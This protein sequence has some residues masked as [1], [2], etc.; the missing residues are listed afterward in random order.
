MHRI[1]GI[2]GV[3]LIFFSAP[4]YSHEADFQSKESFSFYEPNFSE[5]WI[6]DHHFV[7]NSDLV[8]FNLNEYLKTHAPHLLPYSEYISH[9]SGYYS[10]SPKVI[11][12]LIEMQSS[13]ISQPGTPGSMDN[14]LEQLAEETGFNEQIKDVLAHLYS[15]FYQYQTNNQQRKSEVNDTVNAAT[16]ALMNL[17][18]GDISKDEFASRVES[19]KTGFKDVYKQLFPNEATSELNKTV[20]IPQ[21][22]QPPAGFLQFPWKIGESWRFGGVHTTTGGATGAMSSLDFWEKNSGGWGSDTSSYFVTASHAGTVTVFSSCSVRVT[23][24][25]GW[26]TSYYHLDSLTV[27]NGQTVAA[28]QTLG[29]YADNQ[30]QALCNGGSSSG[31]HVHWSLLN[32]GSYTS[33]SGVDLGGYIVH[34]GRHSYDSDPNY[35]WLERNG[36]KYFVPAALLNDASSVPA[37][38][39]LISPSGTI[40]D[41]TPTY[42]WNAVSNSTWYYLWVNDSTGNRIKQW[43]TAAQVGCGSGTGTCSITPSTVLA[44]GSG[45]WWI[46]TWNSSGYGPWST[47]MNFNISGGVPSAANLVSPS[48]T[49]TDTTPTYLWNAVSNSSW[50]YL[51]VN[52]STGNRIQQWYT[53]DQ[54]GCSGG[55]GTCSVTP[56]TVLAN[57][58]GTWWIQTW[59]S[60]GFGPW[61]SGS[62]FNISSGLP[63]AATAISPSG[64]ISDSTPTYSWNA[65]SN[66]TWYYLWV[67]DSTGNRI[68]QWY[69]AAQVGCGTG[70]GVCSINPSTILNNGAGAW[71]VQTWNPNGYGPWNSGLAFTLN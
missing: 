56:A 26:M 40:S 1:I 34:P 12:A 46:Q 58:S 16:Y 7:Y 3:L 51:W 44:A 48:G 29:V 23:A 54:A 27:T 70:T 39:T 71:W 4:S 13:M 69:T 53:A 9:W 25:N 67:N 30:S 49:I 68:Q 31:P 22:A 11:L 8:N 21:G 32:N 36:T 65:V 60:S 57:G 55:T 50:Y 47:G 10:I 62:N 45:T 64:Q 20:N 43:Y 38:A 15:D 17:L 59:N 37:A 2:L 19:D 61:S 6:S 14:P 41:T 52:D 66:S 42:S 35:M 63:P 28:N 18:R 24:A 33:L 5:Q